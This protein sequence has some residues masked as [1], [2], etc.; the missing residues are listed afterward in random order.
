MDVVI[1]NLVKTYNKGEIKAVNDVSLTVEKA[2][3]FGLI[4]P[5]SAGKTSIFRILTTLLLTDSGQ[6]SV[7]GKEVIKQYKSIM[8]EVG[9][10]PG[11]FS[12]YTDLTVEE[13]L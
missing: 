7:N 1:K 9:Y 6:A 8:K 3:L 5:D 13:N 12:L 11:R 10:M 2:E 4:G